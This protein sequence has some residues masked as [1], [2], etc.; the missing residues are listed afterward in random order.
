MENYGLEIAYGAGGGAKLKNVLKLIDE[1]ANLTLA[2]FLEKIKTGGYEVAAP[3]SSA[4][5]SI[6][7]MTMHAAKG[8]EFPVVIIA[9]ICKTFK[10]SDYSEA[11]FDELYG[12]APKCFDYENRITHKTILRRL[13]ALRSDAEELKNEMNLFYVACTRAMCSL[14]ILSEEIKPFSDYDVSY[15]RCYADLFDIGK[16]FPEA[17]TPNGEISAEGNTEPLVYRPDAKLVKRIEER[18]SAPYAYQ[19]CVDLR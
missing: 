10:G 15:A 11:P 1:G 17:L 8:L 3:A 4:S 13:V 9:D 12:F 14:H 19:S 6:K 7:I 18:F 2:A 5:D 16:F